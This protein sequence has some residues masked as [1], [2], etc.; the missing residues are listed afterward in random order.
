MPGNQKLN[1]P[2]CKYKLG[3]NMLFFEQLNDLKTQKQQREFE[4]VET[5]NNRFKKLGL[6]KN[7]HLVNAAVVVDVSTRT[8]ISRA[9]LIK[10]MFESEFTK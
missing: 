1:I 8:T 3:L 9:F 6:V 5:E 10:F 2:N 7:I 4:N